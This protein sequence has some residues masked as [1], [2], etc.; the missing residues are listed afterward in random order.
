MLVTPTAAKQRPPQNITVDP[1]FLFLV[2][3][4]HRFALVVTHPL[5]VCSCRCRHRLCRCLPAR[6]PLPLSSPFALVVTLCPC[7]HRL[8]FA[9]RH[10]LPLSS[11]FAHMIGWPQVATRIRLRVLSQS[12]SPQSI[13]VGCTTYL[14]QV[15]S[16]ARECMPKQLLERHL[17]L[18]S[19]RIT[20][21][22]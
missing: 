13:A 3:C 18:E 7:R 1:S 20:A 21:R 4:R 22:H 5:F 11:P 6:H 2:C 17:A 16:R 14:S 9:C 12:C 15:A 19:Q 10:R 8:S